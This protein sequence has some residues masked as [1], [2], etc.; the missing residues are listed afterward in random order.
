MQGNQCNWG[1]ALQSWWPRTQGSIHFSDANPTSEPSPRPPPENTEKRA[2]E[3]EHPLPPQQKQTDLPTEGQSHGVTQ[4]EWGPTEQDTQSGP[5]RQL[6]LYTAESSFGFVTGVGSTSF[7]SNKTESR[8][9][10]SP[11]GALDGAS[12]TLTSFRARLGLPRI[13]CPHPL[14]THRTSPFSGHSSSS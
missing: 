1:A 8:A 11:A 7:L 10:R 5:G 13:S 4:T 12:H 2:G 14:P 9:D 6:T 3:N